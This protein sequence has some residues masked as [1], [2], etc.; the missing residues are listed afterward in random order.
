MIL[1]K[2]VGNVVS[3]KKIDKII[4]C[5]LLLIEPLYDGGVFVAADTLGAGLGEIVL[6]TTDSSVQAAD[7]RDIPVDALIVGIVDN[8]PKIIRK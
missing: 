4:G 2:V 5:T 1:G 7:D 6:V 3:T 8:E